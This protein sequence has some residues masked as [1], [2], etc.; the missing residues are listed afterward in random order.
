MSCSKVVYL[1]AVLLMM[2]AFAQSQQLPSAGE[3]PVTTEAHLGKGYE[4]LK[5]DRYDVAA[6]EFRAA[7][8]LDPRLTLR[9]RFPLGVALF[10]SHKP[11]EARRE[12]ET[13]RRELGD[14]PNVAYYL[15][16]LAI[17]DRNFDSAI[18]NFSKA[19]EKAPFPDTAYY[20]GFAYSKKGD[21]SAAEK[22]LKEA[23]RAIP[24][25]ARV[26]YQLASVYRQEGHAE[27]AD[28]MFALSQRLHHEDDKESRL[29]VEC[30]QKLEHGSRE[31]AHAVCDQLY[32][33]ENAGKLAALGTIY[34][35]HGDT[36]AA[37]P[38]LRR[39]AELEPESPQMQYNLALAYAQLNRF[40]EARATLEPVVQRWHDL[41]PIN[42]LY[43]TILSK[44][45]ELGPAYEA[46]N[47][48]HNLNPEDLGTR[49]ML[50]TAALA[51]ADERRDVQQYSDSLKYLETATKLRP[52]DP[53]PHHRKAKIYGLMGDPTQAKA[54]S[55]RADRLAEKARV[56]HD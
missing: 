2:R 39:A 10:E 28:K 34:G 53:E 19:I 15:G 13:V 23:Q 29:R 17:E 56:G 46:L 12:F 4:A 30:A 27:E 37:L 8:E 50:Y 9:A 51:I 7:L 31:E 55:E 40:R 44:L 42:A 1:L 24:Q 43:G 38:P 6:S 35:Q 16:R 47:H 11:D 25:D 33:P 52:Q 36:E 41:F 20:L 45:G 26:P 18:R 54:E 5:E 32:D 49:D 48:A 22:W 3:S 21:W 14:H